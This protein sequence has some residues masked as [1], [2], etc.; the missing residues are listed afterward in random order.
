MGVGGI[1]GIYG[2]TGYR[3][4]MTRVLTAPRAPRYSRTLFLSSLNSV[5]VL[6]RDD[7]DLWGRNVLVRFHLERRIFHQERPHVVA[8]SVCMEMALFATWADEPR[9]K[10]K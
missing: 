7:F 1:H 8:Q 2:I 3:Y 5:P 6:T 9:E 4:R 10:S